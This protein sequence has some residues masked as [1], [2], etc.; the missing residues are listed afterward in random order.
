MINRI[1]RSL[2]DNMFLTLSTT[3]FRVG[4]PT[5][6]YLLRPWSRRYARNDTT[7]DK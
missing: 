2:L 6:L 3:Y 7:T 5:R 1:S 4:V